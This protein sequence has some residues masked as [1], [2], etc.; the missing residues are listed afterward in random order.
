MKL[1]QTTPRDGLR[2]MLAGLARLRRAP[3][4]LG[5]LFALVMLILSMLLGLPWVGP[6]LM[7]LLLPALHAGWYEVGRVLQD[8]GTPGPAHLF[9]PLRQPARK[10]LLQ[11]GA[12]QAVLAWLLMAL[13]DLIDPGMSDAWDLFRDSE[14]GDG[15][16]IEAVATLQQGMVLRAAL[17]AP[18]LLAFWHAP[19]VALRTGAGAAKALFVSLT[20]SGRHLGAFVV[21]ALAW[22][23]ADLVLSAA[24]AAVVGVLGLGAIGT[25]LVLPAALMF[26]AAFYASMQVSIDACIDFE[27]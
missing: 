4:A 18:L 14:A 8:G 23:G 2:W 15:A 26:S 9:A 13:G 16:M 24:L 25:V 6:L 7:V 12:L 5:G 22:I 1:C 3:M 11:L 20:A 27:G 21:F 10:V 17:L 19:A